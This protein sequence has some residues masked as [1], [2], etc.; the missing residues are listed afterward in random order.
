MKEVELQYQSGFSIDVVEAVNL[1][2]A[3]RGKP[4]FIECG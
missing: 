1:R 3:L 2:V 4:L